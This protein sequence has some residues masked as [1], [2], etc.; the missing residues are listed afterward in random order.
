VIIPDSSVWIDH[1]RRGNARLSALL[2]AGQAACHEF[3]LGEIACGSHARRAD[4]LEAMRFLPRVAPASHDEV[5][6]LV[7][8]RRL[9][10]RGLGWI[11]AHLLAAAAVA[12]IPLWT[13]DRRLATAAPDLTTL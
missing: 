4:V 1:F 12:G 13:L 8:R 3:I 9:W 6:V 10:G 5:M 2:E 11:D 7:N